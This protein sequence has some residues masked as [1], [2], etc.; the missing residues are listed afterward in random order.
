MEIMIKEIELITKKMEQAYK[1]EKRAYEVSKGWTTKYRNALAEANKRLIEAGL[2]P[3]ES[4][5]GVRNRKSKVM[6]KCAVDGM[7]G[8][9]KGKEYEVVEETEYS[10]KVINERQ[11]ECWYY[12]IPNFETLETEQLSLV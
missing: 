3:V 7:V 10:V 12:K 1:K 8:L 5:W 6:A 2:E 4:P 11:V 9:L